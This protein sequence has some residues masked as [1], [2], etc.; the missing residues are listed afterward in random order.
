MAKIIKIVF[1]ITFLSITRLFAQLPPGLPFIYNFTED[2]DYP[3]QTWKIIK[4]NDGLLYLASEKYFLRFDGFKFTPLHTFNAEAVLSV[5]QRGNVFY[6]GTSTGIFV[7]EFQDDTLITHQLKLNSNLPNIRYILKKNSSLYFFINKKDVVVLKHNQLE[8]IPRPSNFQI[9]RGFLVDTNIFAV[10]LKGIAIINNNNKLKI[11]SHTHTYIYKQD[12]RFFLPLST[13]NKFLI[14]TKEGGLYIYN[15]KEDTFKPFEITNAQIGEPLFYTASIINDTLFALGTLDKGLFIISSKGRLILHLHRENGLESNAIYNILVDQNKNL[16]LGTSK[17]LSFVNLN[18]KLY[19]FG[20]HNGINDMIMKIHIKNNYLMVPTAEKFIIFNLENY[21][22]K[23]VKDYQFKYGEDFVDLKMNKKNY[24]LVSAY[25]KYFILDDNLKLVYNHKG[26]NT[27]LLKPTGYDSTTFY[28]HGK[29]FKQMKLVQRNGKIYAVDKY[30]YRSLTLSFSKIYLDK[31]NDLWLIF[32]SD[33]FCLDTKNSADSA[34]IRHYFINSLHVANIFEIGNKLYFKTDSGLY[35]TENKKDKPDS[36]I[37]VKDTMFKDFNF[38]AVLYIDSFYYFLSDIKGKIYKFKKHKIIDSASFPAGNF[39]KKQ[40]ISYKDFLL[41]PATTKIFVIRKD[42]KN[43]LGNIAKQEIRFL[44]STVNQRV[45]AIFKANQKEKKIIL[46]NKIPDKSEFAFY[47]TITPIRI[48]NYTFYYKL[49]NANSWQKLSSNEVIFRHL[50]FGHHTLQIKAVN[51]NDIIYSPELSFFVKPPLWLQWWALILYLALLFFLVVLFIRVWTNRMRKRKI[52]LEAEIER[53]A[54]ELS[55]QKD[56]LKEREELVE[57]HKQQLER[58]TKKLKLTLFELKQMSLAVQNSEDSVLIVNKNGKFE[59]WNRSFAELFKYKFEQYQDLPPKEFHKKLRPDVY[60]ELKNYDISKGVIQY[61]SH[62][63]FDNGDEIWYKTTITPI[64]EGN[65]LEGYIVLDKILSDYKLLENNLFNQK[66]MNI[67][68]KEK[69]NLLKAENSLLRSEINQL[70]YLDNKNK[71][72]AEYL[73][74]ALDTK[75]RLEKIFSAYIIVDIP[76]NEVSGDFIWVRKRQDSI[77]IALG[78]A[79]GHRVKGAIMSS[80]AHLMLNHSLRTERKQP[81]E[82][83]EDVNNFMCDFFEKNNIDKDALFLAVAEINLKDN[84]LIFAGARIPLIIYKHQI[85]E[86]IK[87]PTHRNTLGLKKD[88]K[89]S[90]EIIDIQK[91]DTIYMYSDGWVNQLGSMGV[92]KYSHKRILQFIQNIQDINFSVH[93][94]LITR[95]IQEW[96]KNFEQIDDIMVL[97]IKI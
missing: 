23:I 55:E 9:L 7:S 22:Q 90:N 48:A 19:Y 26:N 13:K 16:W 86:A 56:K 2:K 77:Y 80:I 37:T 60:R 70:K 27:I 57:V 45:E 6:L 21:E 66:E 41:F 46:P 36:L 34:E 53:R 17:G 3:N 67:L 24:T 61:T 73:K 79:P 71:I 92:K 39:S 78:D 8:Q 59:W 49:D 54:K 51:E 91:N 18:N 97:G 25:S 69:I 96:R 95:E 63:I 44:Y 93:D 88:L 50:E 75:S 76:H 29:I 72:Y 68:L 28:Y 38:S 31:Y 84:K 47:F 20:K 10:S 74:K 94:K 15:K 81:S 33:I 30:I 42:F 82:I 62:E 12:I 40:I 87:L 11:I 35:V 14:G 43:P 64:I 5:E 58:E 4:G 83:L 85:K 89:F 52:A 65:K 32:S 1:L